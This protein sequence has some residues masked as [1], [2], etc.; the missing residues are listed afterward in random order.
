[1]TATRAPTQT[2]TDAPSLAP[3]ATSPPPA[4]SEPAATGTEL[5]APELLAPED[6]QDFQPDA[7]IVLSW[8]PVGELPADAFYVV[9]V[10]YLHLGETWFDDVPWTRDTSWTLS[11]HDYLK[12]LSDNDEYRW[13]VRVMR[14]TGTDAGGK[15]VGVPLSPSS[16]ERLV[17]WKS[18]ASGGPGAPPPP[19]PPLIGP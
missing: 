1:V 11:E 14:Q 3:T 13:S 2:P 16:E 10:A 7:E 18:Q 9:S 6:R 12:D 15:P 4:P 17:I 8:E 19:P 5:P